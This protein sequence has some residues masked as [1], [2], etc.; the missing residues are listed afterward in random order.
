MDF[1]VHEAKTQFSRLLDLAQ[2]GE[3]VTITRNGTPVA[4]LIPV[5]K[6]GS[7]LLG[8][9]RGTLMNESDDWWQAADGEEVEL[10]HGN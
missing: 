7:L 4:E 8:S 3:Q 2:Q 6:K 5:R 1:N 9:A 10:W